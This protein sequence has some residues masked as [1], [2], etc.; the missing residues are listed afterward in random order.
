MGE[1]PTQLSLN[2][3]DDEIAV[4]P[5]KTLACHRQIHHYP[6]RASSKNFRKVP[7]SLNGTKK[8]SN[9]R[10]V[11]RHCDKPDST[12][13]NAFCAHR[14][15]LCSNS[16]MKFLRRESSRHPYSSQSNPIRHA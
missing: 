1:Q 14:E 10:C 15:Y 12:F 2:V 8:N 16:L 5:L 6:R 7:T 4:D 3:C 9:R 11:W 13:C